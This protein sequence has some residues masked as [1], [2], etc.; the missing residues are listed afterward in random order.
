MHVGAREEK[1]SLGGL[2]NLLL[3]ISD[4]NVSCEDNN[5]RVRSQELRINLTKDGKREDPF[6]YL[7]W[8][9]MKATL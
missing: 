2:K 6:H 8:K 4:R 7:V 5:H 1:V 3:N 9:T